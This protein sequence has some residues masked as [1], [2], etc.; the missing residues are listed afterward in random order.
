MSSDETGEIY[1]IMRKNG[2]P[3]SSVGSNTTG[4][5]SGS[6][7]T[8]TPNTAGARSW[9]ALAVLFGIIAFVI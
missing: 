6:G 7:P 8:S 5:G 9:S 2:D 1:A 4:T 3:T